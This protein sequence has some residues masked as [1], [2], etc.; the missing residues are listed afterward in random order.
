MKLLKQLMYPNP[1]ELIHVLLLLLKQQGWSLNDNIKYKEKK[2]CKPRSTRQLTLQQYRSIISQEIEL[3]TYNIIW[4]RRTCKLLWW[5]C[6]VYLFNLNPF[7]I[8]HNHLSISMSSDSCYSKDQITILISFFNVT[9]SANLLY[10]K[11]K[12]IR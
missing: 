2:K 10:S 6:I 8:F 11:I 5:Y 7:T 3:S 12:I 4:E 9:I 1:L